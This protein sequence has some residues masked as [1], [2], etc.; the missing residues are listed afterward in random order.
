MTEKEKERQELKELWDKA[1]F[2]VEPKKTTV[3][4]S[5]RNITYKADKKK[6]K[7]EKH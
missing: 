2:K 6:K 7:N 5:Y 4:G 3:I 1:T